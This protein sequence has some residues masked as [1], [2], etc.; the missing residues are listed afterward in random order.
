MPRLK[1]SFRAPHQFVGI[2]G[3]HCIPRSLNKD[4]Q[5]QT[6]ATLLLPDNQSKIQHL[7]E[8]GFL[9]SEKSALDVSEL[10]QRACRAD[11]L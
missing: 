11:S 9:P 6:A 4:A 2:R 7:S 10:R 8:I 3:P 1:D 5:T